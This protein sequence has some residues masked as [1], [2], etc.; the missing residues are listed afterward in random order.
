MLAK[1]L[2]QYWWVLLLRG[3][4]AVLFGVTAY[5]WP[6]LTPATLSINGRFWVSREVQ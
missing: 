2:S 6:G 3:I 1:L 5:V 4:V